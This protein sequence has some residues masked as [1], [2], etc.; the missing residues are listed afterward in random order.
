MRTF[1]TR[2]FLTKEEDEILQNYADLCSQVERSLFTD[3]QRQITSV[4]E[5]K[6]AYL[7]KYGITARQFNGCRASVEGKMRSLKEIQKQRI[8][9][10]KEKEKQ[11]EKKLSS[12]RFKG[13][14]H[15]THQVLQR[16]QSLCRQLEGDREKGVVRI[17]F[18]GRKLFKA[19][20]NLEENGFKSHDEWKEKWQS[21]RNAIFFLMGSKDEAGGNQSCT[22]SLSENGRFT[23]RL[24]LP[25]IL[26]VGRYMTLSEVSFCYGHKIIK[27]ALLECLESG[28][29]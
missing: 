13:N 23:M 18:G 28:K 3:L 2:L 15:Q 19:Q 1:Q 9:D 7:K 10:L 24:R 8:I 29:S 26:S 6:K 21:K 25:D 5:L 20:Y 27:R 11:L 4:N 17:C 16:T 22:A 12:R 14:R